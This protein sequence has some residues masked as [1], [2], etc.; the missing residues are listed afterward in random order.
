MENW[1]DKIIVFVI[2]ILVVA[3]WFI[4]YK[5]IKI[6]IKSWSKKNEREV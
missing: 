4:L 5:D 1:V 3:S 2:S 6:M